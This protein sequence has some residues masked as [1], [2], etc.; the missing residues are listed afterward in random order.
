[1]ITISGQGFQ[2]SGTAAIYFDTSAAPIISPLADATGSFISSFTVPETYQGLHYLLG[3]DTVN[4]TSRLSFTV[5]P[6][7]KVAQINTS[8]DS[9]IAVSGSGFSGASTI[10][11]YLDIVKIDTLA[12]T[13][14]AGSFASVKITI[15]TIS[16]GT[17]TLKVLDSKG[18]Y[19]NS[20][21]TV[22]PSISLNPSSGSAGSPIK[23]KGGGFASNIRVYI[24]Y[25]DQIMITEPSIIKSDD[26][27][28][29]TASILAPNSSSG[30][31]SIRATDLTNNGTSNF[32]LNTSARLEKTSGI[33]G[34]EIPVTGSG[35][36]AG[37]ALNI[38]F[39]NSAVA[40][41]SVGSDGA[42]VS[43]IKVPPGLPGQ[44]KVTITDGFNPITLSFFV[45]AS[46]QIS[47]PKG[48]G[49]QAI[50][51]VGSPVTITG[52]GF[53]PGG[54]ANI[55]YDSEPVGSAT[56][57][58]AGSFT[59]VFEAPP[60]A[61]GNHIVTASDGVNEFSFIF[62]MDATPPS[63]PMCLFPLKE[64]KADSLTRFQWVAVSDA[65]GVTYRFQLST[66]PS[67][68]TLVI[69]QKSL[70]GPA[71][72]LTP[73]QNLKAAGNNLP[74]YWRVQAIDNASN[75]SPWSAS[76]TFYVGFVVPPYFLYAFYGLTG[77]VVF[78][79]GV[80]IGTR[81]GSKFS[82]ISPRRKEEPEEPTGNEEAVEQEA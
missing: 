22:T 69:D 2:K 63:A 61:G 50:G 57:T 71:Y 43:S 17:H 13:N 56:T 54:T 11:F 46:A 21:I 39:D 4:Y 28:S 45:E 68:K 73:E 60:S 47:T 64:D 78:A 52:S 62:I 37:A 35:F 80:V 12:S 7:V 42:F 15:P 81:W 33:A 1:M 44:H 30:S 53:T 26:S 75:A 76:S 70:P 40:S 48:A 24:S 19:D 6:F 32:T 36:K 23:I 5:N 79:G 77:L 66:D 31:F 3:K 67:F 34:S 41:V 10:S 27:G 20:K 65:S 16:G 8:T 72:Q 82:F 58:E 18:F 49:K 51:N 14:S 38:K 25:Q 55:T 59:A 29:F 74:Y 9:Q